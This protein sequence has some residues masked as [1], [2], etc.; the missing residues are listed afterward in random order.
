MK[1]P[2]LSQVI[3]NLWLLLKWIINKIRTKSQENIKH[4]LSGSCSSGLENISIHLEW[5]SWSEGMI[6]TTT[7]LFFFLHVSTSTHTIHSVNVND[8]NEIVW[9]DTPTKHEE[10]IRGI[11]RHKQEM[12]MKEQIEKMVRRTRLN[13]GTTHSLVSLSKKIN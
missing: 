2:P 13:S 1:T 12:E 11:L 6:Q 7:K 5:T 9:F 10:L 8:I 3:Y 4:Q